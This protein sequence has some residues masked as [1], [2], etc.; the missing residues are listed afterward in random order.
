[1]WNCAGDGKCGY[2]TRDELANAYAKMLTD[3]KHNNNTYNLTGEAISQNRL[4][5]LL[6]TTFGTGLVFNNMSVPD[7]KADR[8]AELG[9]FLGTVIAGI[10]EGIRNGAVDIRSDYEQAAGRPHI[11]WEDY[12]NHMKAKL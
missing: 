12:F 9:D 11:G 3:D 10:Y 2:T 5:E 1:M 4:V 6:N 7:Y 8:K